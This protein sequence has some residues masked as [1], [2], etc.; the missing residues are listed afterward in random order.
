MKLATSEPFDD[1]TLALPSLG[2]DTVCQWMEGSEGIRLPNWSSPCTLKRAV[3]LD[4]L[5]GVLAGTVCPLVVRVTRV[6][7][8]GKTRNERL[9]VADRP[10]RS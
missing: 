5:S 7:R 4:V 10:E 1:V 8:I 6:V 3:V 2:A 9:R